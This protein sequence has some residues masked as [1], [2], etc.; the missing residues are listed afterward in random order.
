MASDSSQFPRVTEIMKITDTDEGNGT[1]DVEVKVQYAADAV[2]VPEKYRS[3]PKDPFGVNPQIREW[4]RQNPDAPVHVYVPP[5]EPTKAELRAQMPRL[6]ARQF[7]LGLVNAGISPAQVTA[8]LEAMPPSPDTDKA[9][10]E[11]EYATEF[12]RLHPLIATVGTQ[13]NLTADQIDTMWLASV[14]L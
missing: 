10:I 14:N 1:Y 8:A 9:L 4:M 12:K 13:L 11:W 2:S 3:R 7:R 6:T 5:P